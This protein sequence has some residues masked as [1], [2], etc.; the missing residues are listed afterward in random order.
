MSDILNG[1]VVVVTG[2]SS[3]I[4]RAIALRAAE[5]GARA[6]IVSDVTETPREGGEPAAEVIRALG[7]PALFV[8]ADVS[9]RTENDAL[10]AA[11]CSR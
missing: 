3:G 4:G 2:A 7:V 5:H 9:K 1:K 6:V 11:A 8:K 10:V